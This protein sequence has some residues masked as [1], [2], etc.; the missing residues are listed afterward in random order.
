MYFGGGREEMVTYVLAL[1]FCLCI[2]LRI[3]IRFFFKMGT[4]VRLF[5]KYLVN[6][7]GAGHGSRHLGV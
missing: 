6:S 3:L 1:D 2:D 7:I 5:G 4:L